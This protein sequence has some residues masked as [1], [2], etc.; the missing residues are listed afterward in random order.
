MAVGT[1]GGAGGAIAPPNILPIKK[2]KSLR[3]MTYKSVYSNKDKI[4]F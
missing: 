2:F 4:G 1:G 3:I